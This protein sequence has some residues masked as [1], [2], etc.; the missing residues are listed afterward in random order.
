MMHTEFRLGYIAASGGT[1]RVYDTALCLPHFASPPLIVTGAVG[2][3][4]NVFTPPCVRHACVA[5]NF[6]L[7]A[8]V[9]D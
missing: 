8:E 9:I 3:K 5:I 1:R 7:S 4:T 6:P 2:W